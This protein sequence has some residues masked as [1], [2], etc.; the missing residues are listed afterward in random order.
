MKKPRSAGLIAAGS[1][2]DS[3]LIHFHRLSEVLGPVKSPSYRLASRISNLL[4]AGHPVKDYADLESCG[5]IL[6]W[7]PGQ[8]VPRIVAELLAGK[9]S[10]RGKCVV[11]F[12]DWQ[13]SSDL[14]QLAARGAS[15]GSI[16]PIPGFDNLFLVEGDR[17]AILEGKRLVESR[18]TRTVAIERALKP[19][20]LA[21]LTCTSSLLFA[22]L[23]AASESLRHAGI[24]PVLRATLLERQLNRTLRAFHKGGRRA[25]QPP[26][27]LPRQLRTLAAQDAA[28]AHYFEQTSRLASRL[29][30]E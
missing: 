2:T 13:D 4:R 8:Q 29:L 16:S 9:I 10:W 7:V 11:L 17:R 30:E 26:Q 14:R 1:L 18:G 6:I 21:A 20:Y 12:S 25:Y 23:L 24:T 28:L 27:E 19:L 5:L 3:P 15:V 22:L